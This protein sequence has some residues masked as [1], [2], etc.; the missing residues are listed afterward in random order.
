MNISH[1][2]VA[3]RHMTWNGINLNPG[4]LFGH[5]SFNGYIY[6][7]APAAGSFVFFVR[8]EDNS[9]CACPI[10]KLPENISHWETDDGR[11]FFEET[12]E[13]PE[14]YPVALATRDGWDSDLV[15]NLLEE[16]NPNK[17]VA[18]YI[19]GDMATFFINPIH[20]SPDFGEYGELVETWFM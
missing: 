6:S 14:S 9:N 5:D 8:K 1:L 4:D 19:D 7:H 13:R 2:Y 18:M 12:V 10:T 17:E 16:C 20:S 11:I 3:D 15:M